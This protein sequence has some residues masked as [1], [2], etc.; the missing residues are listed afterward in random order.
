M[1]STQ[2]VCNRE[3]PG[4]ICCFLIVSYDELV[5]FIYVK[6]VL[7]S[8]NMLR[9]LNT[10]CKIVGKNLTSFQNKIFRGI[11]ENANNFLSKGVG[12]FQE[13]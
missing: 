7:Q 1:I 13:T 10:Y 11:F 9:I 2:L 12:T 5:H 4:T 6:Q 3:L 8:N